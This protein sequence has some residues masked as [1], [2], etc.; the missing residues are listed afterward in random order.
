MT[1]DVRRLAEEAGLSQ[2]GTR[3]WSEEFSA[4]ANLVLEAAA[5]EIA[6]MRKKSVHVTA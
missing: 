4:F 2:G 6:A 3:S 1:I 5:V